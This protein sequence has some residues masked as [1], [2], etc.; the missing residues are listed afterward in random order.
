MVEW[1]ANQYMVF[2]KQRSHPA[3]DLAMRIQHNTYKSIVDIGCGPG[4][5]TAI[6]QDVFPEAS[7]I[8]IDN[9]KDMIEKA[10]IRCPDLSFQKCG[11]EE[12]EGKYDLLFSN[13]C[14]QWVPNHQVL[15][16]SLLEK[17]NENGVLAVQM[18]Y[19]SAEPLYEIVSQVVKNPKWRLSDKEIENNVTLARDAYFAILS[20]YASRFELWETKYY[21]IL[22]THQAMLDWIKSTKIRPY[23]SLLEEE[24]REVF[25]KE[26]LEK[27]IQQY[28]TNE[29]G[30]VVFG[31]N[32]L[33]FIA[34]K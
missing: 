20:K 6:L 11:V 22:P 28:P 1:N 7:I 12:L 4:N 25:E 27:A 19:N 29:H 15:L 34:Y 30:E 18:P 8:G 10:R 17:L 32:R 33:F 9:S 24:E 31:F 26:I 13:A 3:I 21:H 2:E 5:S 14:L 23:L 16:P